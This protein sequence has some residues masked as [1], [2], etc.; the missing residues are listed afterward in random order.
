MNLRIHRHLDGEL[1]GSVLSDAERREAEALRKAMNAALSPLRD[2][3]APDVSEAVVAAVSARA[4]RKEPPTVA[5]HGRAR[6]SA[7]WLW[8]PRSVTV[9]VR[10]AWGM[11][12]AAVLLLT[13]LW[14]RGPEAPPAG[15]PIQAGG[16]V[17]ATAGVEG[18]VLVVFRLDAPGARSVRLAG[19]FTGWEP[20]PVLT[21]RT[22]GVWTVLVP[23]EPG[24]H[25]YAFVVDGTRWVQDP[26]AERVDDG[27]GGTNSRVAV[28]VPARTDE[29]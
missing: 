24:L 12:A 4:P 15:T 26:F 10:P 1:R 6:R 25:D 27:F 2:E 28:L 14:T 16:T 8:T 13:T 22:P 17:M 29:T 11:A 7:A 9:R 19:D 21:Q 20:G 18:T 3:P 23:V 5:S